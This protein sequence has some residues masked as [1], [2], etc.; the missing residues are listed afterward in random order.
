MYGFTQ[1]KQ[2]FGMIHSSIKTHKVVWNY[3]D[4]FARDIFAPNWKEERVKT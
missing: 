3:F 2:Q 4:D 1:I